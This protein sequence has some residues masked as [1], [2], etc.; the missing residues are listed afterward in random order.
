M[1]NIDAGKF[2]AAPAVRQLRLPRC[3][4]P[5]YSANVLSRVARIFLLHFISVGN[6]INLPIYRR[7]LSVGQV[8]ASRT[9]ELRLKWSAIDCCHITLLRGVCPYGSVCVTQRTTSFIFT[10]CTESRE[11]FKRRLSLVRPWASYSLFLRVY[12]NASRRG[13]KV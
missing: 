7:R 11:S 12:N 2:K 1:C 6:W 8:F 3:C 5:I 4:A 13:G 10:C 9:V